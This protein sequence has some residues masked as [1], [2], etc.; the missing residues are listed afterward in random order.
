MRKT[1]LL[2]FIAFWLAALAAAPVQAVF[3][4]QGEELMQTMRQQGVTLSLGAEL[5]TWEHL[6]QEDTPAMAAWLKDMA[7]RLDI[8]VRR[9]LAHNPDAGRARCVPHRPDPAGAEHPAHTW[10]ADTAL[11]AAR[12]RPLALPAS[13]GMD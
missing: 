3:S 2:G 4:P 7:L 6:P 5:A 13:A 9:P 8:A 12:R 11:L 1:R 10:P